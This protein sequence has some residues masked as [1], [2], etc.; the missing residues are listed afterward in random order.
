MLSRRIVDSTT[1]M[2]LRQLKQDHHLSVRAPQ[3]RP[4]PRDPPR[5]PRRSSSLPLPHS[6]TLFKCLIACFAKLVL[7]EG[8]AAHK[9][10]SFKFI[11]LDRQVLY[12]DLALKARAI[13]F[14]RFPEFGVWTITSFVVCR[15]YVTHIG[16]WMETSVSMGVR[17]KWNAFVTCFGDLTHVTL[18]GPVERA[19]TSREGKRSALCIIVA[20]CT[21]SLTSVCIVRCQRKCLLVVRRWTHWKQ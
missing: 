14:Y 15:K 18:S 7:R 4:I 16:T 8:R 19:S 12:L 20:L 13:H 11:R 6:Q 1:E 21:D 17:G 9:H 5:N 2:P 10:S 3:L